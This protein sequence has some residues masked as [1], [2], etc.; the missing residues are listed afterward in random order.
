MSEKENPSNIHQ[1]VPLL[2]R[3]LG[4]MNGLDCLRTVDSLYVKQYTSLTE[5]KLV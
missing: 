3:T 2:P 5:G 1:T 4:D